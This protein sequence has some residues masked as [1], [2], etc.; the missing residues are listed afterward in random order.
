MNLDDYWNPVETDK[1]FFGVPFSWG[2]R[3]CYEDAHQVVEKMLEKMNSDIVEFQMI[4]RFII[5]L[6][7]SP[8]CVIVSFDNGFDIKIGFSIHSNYAS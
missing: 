7:C 3:S 4:S 2:N 6:V 8:D 5:G 1:E